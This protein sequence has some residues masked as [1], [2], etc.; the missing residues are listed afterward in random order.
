MVGSFKEP[1]KK[2]KFRLIALDDA[3]D[4]DDDGV[5]VVISVSDLSLLIASSG[6]GMLGATGGGGGALGSTGG[7]GELGRS[8]TSGSSLKSSSERIC[9]LL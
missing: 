1:E 9:A 6:G 4:D 2:A 7:I 5:G 3:I 8:Y